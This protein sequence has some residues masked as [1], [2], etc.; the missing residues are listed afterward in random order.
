MQSGK[1]RHHIWV[2]RKD[3]TRNSYGEE[4]TVWEDDVE[5]WASIMPVRGQEYFAASSLNI[6]VTHR[7]R[8][9]FL[10]MSDGSRITPENRIKFVDKESVTRYFG[11][12]GVINVDERNIQLDLMCVEEL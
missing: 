1:L 8:A 2:Q 9:R 6:V 10:R 5:A 7:I 4:T 12:K 11:I 3:T